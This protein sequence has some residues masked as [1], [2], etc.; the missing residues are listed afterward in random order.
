MNDEALGYCY[1]ACSNIPLLFNSVFT[2]SGSCRF[3]VCVG[4][5]CTVLIHTS[6]FSIL[7]KGRLCAC[8]FPP[9]I[10]VCHKKDKRTD[11]LLVLFGFVVQSQLQATGWWNS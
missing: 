8:P 4:E 3:H 10:S 6:A 2:C 7:L 9:S 1:T 5:Y 11:W